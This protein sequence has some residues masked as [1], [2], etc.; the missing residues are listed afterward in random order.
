MESVL[1][2]FLA[3]LTPIFAHVDIEVF[4]AN[5][6]H[7]QW[8]QY[9]QECEYMVGI[10]KLKDSKEELIYTSDWLLNNYLDIEIDEEGSYLWKVYIKEAGKRCSSNEYQCFNMES[11]YFDLYLTQEQPVTDINPRIEEGVHISRDIQE[12][13]WEEEVLGISTEKYIAKKEF[14]EEEKEIGGSEENKKPKER[15]TPQERNYCKYKYDIKKKLF[16]LLECSIDH[17][18]ITSSTYYTYNNQ[19]IVNSKG[20]YRDSITVYID[21]F[22]CSDFDI[23]DSKTWFKCNEVV[24]DT[25][26]YQVN[27]SHEVYFLKEKIVSP[28]SYIFRYDYFEISTLV[29]ELPTD[30]IFKGYFSINHRNQWLDQELAFKKSTTF[31]EIKDVSNGI[32]S[33]PFSKIVYVNQWHGCTVYQCP[34]KGIDFASVRENIYASDSGTVVARGYDNFGGECNSGGNYLVVK[35][36]SGHHMAYMHLEKIYVQNGQGVKKGDLIAL[37]GNSGAHN[38]QPLG[39][40][41]HFELREAR[42]QST[43]IDPVPFIDIDWNL[44]K[45]N[46]RDVYPGRLSGDNPHPTF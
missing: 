15:E 31:E 21:S 44:V 17:P 45:T 35:Y 19:K 24:T 43:H 11:G 12:D 37:S 36:N 40:H 25:D 38:C 14:L 9:A 2:I 30:L 7:I 4:N 3:F 29:K 5:P 16:T 33:F 22:I 23:L 8:G 26:N 41:L 28:T 32:Y 20:T 6:V 1:K 27:L 46:K 34:H 13:I 18:N 10:Y 39:H 42:A